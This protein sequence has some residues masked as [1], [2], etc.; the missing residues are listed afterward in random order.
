[1]RYGS[2]KSIF[3]SCQHQLKFDLKYL[4]VRQIRSEMPTYYLKLFHRSED[5]YL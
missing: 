4:K 2:L 5:I 1:M 3:D